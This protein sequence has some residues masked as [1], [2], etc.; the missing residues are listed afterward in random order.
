MK[1]LNK[2]NVE[3]IMSLTPL[4]EGMLFH[5]LTSPESKVYYEYLKLRISGPVD[6]QVLCQAINH[7]VQTNEAL[8]TV[9]RWEKLRKSIQV[10]LKEKTVPINEYHIKSSS[11]IDEQL[12]E[13]YD[14]ER[15]DVID[16]SENPFQV[17]IC[18]LGDSDVVLLF[19]YH[20]IIFDGWS[21]GIIIHE[22]LSA[23]DK[24]YNR[25]PLASDY[26][27]GA[28]KAFI[29]KQMQQDKKQEQG[30][31]N[32]YLKEYEF[33]DF[34]PRENNLSTRAVIKDVPRQ[35]PR[36]L[37][38][39]MQ[40][41][42]RSH[43]LTVSQILYY[44][45]AV[46]LHKY[47]GSDDVVMGTT[48]SGRSLPI[49]GIE[50][51]VGLYINTIPLRMRFSENKKTIEYLQDLARDLPLRQQFE[52]TALTDIQTY[53][54]RKSSDDLFNTLVV[55]EN[56][57]L[58]K[59]SSTVLTVEDFS[60]E[61]TNN[62]DI[63][64]T[65]MLM[66]RLEL[67]FS[68]NSTLYSEQAIKALSSHYVNLIT[69]IVT[70]PQKSP[71]QLEMMSRDEKDLLTYTWNDTYFEYSKDTVWPSIFEKN[72]ASFAE[73][74][75]L[76]AGGKHYSYGEIN[77]K[78]NSLAH[79]LREK[80]GG[81][82]TIVAVMAERTAD[83]FISLI[84]ILK[85]GCAYLPIDPS[86]PAERVE[87]IVSD[88]AAR[89]LLVPGHLKEKA[90]HTDRVLI[91]EDGF[92]ENA[93]DTNLPLINKGDDMIYAIYTSGS[94]GKPK[95]VKLSHKNVLN[96]M[97]AISKAIDFSQ[98][99]TIV[100][101]TN[102]TFD[103]FV[104][105][106]MVALG[107]GQTVVLAGEEEQITPKL[108]AG[109]MGEHHVDMI[110]T[111]PSRLQLMMNS[112]YKKSLKPLKE[113]ILGGEA[114]PQQ[115]LRDLKEVTKARI[116]NVYGPTETTVWS[117]VKELTHTDSITI[118]KPLLNTQI[119]LLD[120][121]KQLCPIGVPGDLYIGGD[122]VAIE[123]I[124]RPDL[125]AEK[126]I[127]NPLNG[128]DSIYKTGDKARWLPSG[129]IEFLGR[130]DFQ[131]KIRGFRVELG[132]IE[133]K[134]LEL[135]EI[136]EAVVICSGLENDARLKAFIVTQK[137]VSNEHIVKKLSESLPYYMIPAVYISVEKMPLTTSGKVDRKTLVAMKH[138]IS[139]EEAVVDMPRNELQKMILDIWGEV[140]EQD[141]S[142]IGINQPFFEVGGSSISL[143][144]LHSLIDKKFPD[145]IKITDIFNNPT[146]FH[147]ASF[148]QDSEKPEG[149]GISFSYVPFPA[150]FFSPDVQDESNDLYFSLSK[151]KL[152]NIEAV[153]EQ[154]DITFYSVALA[155][156]YNLLQQVSSGQQIVVQI[157]QNHKEIVPLEVDFGNFEG[158]LDLIL[159]FE[160]NSYLQEGK[161][162][163]S[164]VSASFDN[165]KGH[166]VLP[167]IYD[168]NKLSPGDSVYKVFDMVLGIENRIDDIAFYCYFNQ[169]RLNKLKVAEFIDDYIWLLE[170]FNEKIVEDQEIVS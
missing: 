7:V 90:G 55:I 40:S 108:L 137:P 64:L 26:Q 47:T 143:I 110:Q 68:Y 37:Y 126:F 71:G 54:N 160:K 13:I 163:L 103:I 30:F 53:S 96:Y 25:L 87:Y 109:I 138:D 51:S 16:L 27:K 67:T 99:K 45:W 136:N 61:E 122:G 124:N 75:A 24:L 18:Y 101:V 131:V 161:I 125:T 100:S 157:A 106:F 62:Y 91:I 121:N 111:T 116:Y 6:A 123:Y 38:D 107:Q 130:E 72:A 133:N 49:Q 2:A 147:I 14:R 28:I 112:D 39:S 93:P 50:Q 128:E 22:L 12:R 69:G 152:N 162:N 134:L 70:S 149:P 58:E 95:G 154:K 113:I 29:Q 78:A 56:Y 80:G 104:T 153:M 86:Y 142:T 9:F 140:L 146:V 120:R 46:L 23:Y 150:D 17:S 52:N 65:F 105:E 145:K 60:M 115:L 151:E 1:K 159:F 5:Y 94:T 144:R 21:T 41:F 48:V 10:I 32:E 31:W 34:L 35:F 166:D 4:Q 74:T 63:T 139:P 97:Y 19:K 155:L 127:A 82:N 117:T 141:V 8:R 165:K 66:D 167:L 79:M 102:I 158:F 43:H 76:I 59:N 135:E 15:Q 84:G 88:S 42:A 148:I 77:R 57:P 89:F 132:E 168:R 164:E 73:K 81:R 92:G 85:A 11:C 114:F 44:A 33:K 3:E 169:Q 36:D 129:D 170:T 83:L 20:H 119:Y 156:F 98:D 118:G